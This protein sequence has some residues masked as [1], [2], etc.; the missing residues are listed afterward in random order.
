MRLG[1]RNANEARC[2]QVNLCKALAQN[3]CT[4]AGMVAKGQSYEV[5]TRAP[6]MFITLQGLRWTWWE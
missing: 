2:S 4:M 1:A 6:Q 5:R 3:Q